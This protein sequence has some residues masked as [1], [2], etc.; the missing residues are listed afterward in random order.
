MLRWFNSNTSSLI[1]FFIFNGNFLIC[2]VSLNLNSLKFLKYSN[3]V[4]ML[5]R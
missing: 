3:S 1:Q 5:L 2:I 4:G